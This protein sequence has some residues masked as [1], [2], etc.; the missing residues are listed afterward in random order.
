MR[1][2]D[3]LKAKP[4]QKES[5]R[6]FRIDDQDT[7]YT[8]TLDP[9]MRDHRVIALII[10]HT[11]KRGDCNFYRSGNN[12]KQCYIA[13]RYKVIWSDC[14]GKCFIHGLTCPLILE[15]L[16]NLTESEINNKNIQE[17]A[18]RTLSSA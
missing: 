10:D 3:Q 4:T 1:E 16:E 2:D 13:P 5:D 14:E 8:L 9:T 7:Y 15:Y 11:S 18:A 17:T 6:T 12:Q